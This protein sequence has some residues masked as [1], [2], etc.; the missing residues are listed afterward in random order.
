MN[1]P[2]LT[3]GTQER[4]V[5]CDGH[6]HESNVA[7][8]SNIVPHIHVTW[9]CQVPIGTNS[10]YQNS[11]EHKGCVVSMALG[12]NGLKHKRREQVEEIHDARYHLHN[13]AF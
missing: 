10:N 8:C 6:G 4:D 3:L 9:Q 11:K 13:S 12:V 2:V 5:L 7:D 1:Y